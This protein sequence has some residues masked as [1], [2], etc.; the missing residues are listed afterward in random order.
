[1]T[2]PEAIL[3]LVVGLGLVLA[4]LQALA[5]RALVRRPPPPCPAAWLPVSILRPLKG[6]DPD[7]AENLRSLFRL[8]YPEFEIILGTEEPDDPALG[9]ARRVAAE[10]PHVRAAIVS[11]APAIGFNPRSEEH[12]SELQSLRHLV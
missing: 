5:Q 1:M 12:T 6:A 3:T 8:A 7:L 9:V 4:L 11:Q 2:A 10:F